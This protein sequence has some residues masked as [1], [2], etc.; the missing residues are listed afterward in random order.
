[1]QGRCDAALALVGADDAAR[2]QRSVVVENGSP[3]I[4]NN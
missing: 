4:I 2:W 3:F 1:M